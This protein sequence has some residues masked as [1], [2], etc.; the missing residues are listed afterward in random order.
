MLTVNIIGDVFCLYFYG[1]LESVAIVSIFTFATGVIYG[2]YLL[3]KHINV[4]FSNLFIL[5]YKEFIFKFNDLTKNS[6]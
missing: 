4:S 2:M 5:G 1:T 3:N 6:L